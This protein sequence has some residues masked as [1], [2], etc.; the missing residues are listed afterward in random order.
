[1]D[2][3]K[4]AIYAF[5]LPQ[6]HPIKENDIW[7]GKGFTEWT[8]VGKAKK[9]FKQHYQPRV[10]ADLGYYDLRLPDIR[11]MQAELAKTYGI[12][13]FLYWHYWF[14]HGKQLLERPFQ[15][16]LQDKR[17][18][19][20][21]ALAWANE[22]WEI[23]DHKTN[24]TKS[25][26]TQAY[27]SEDDYIKHFM[28]ILQAF[29][30]DRYIKIDGKPLFLIYKPNSIPC[31]E[32]FIEL[33]NKLAIL[34][35]FPGIYFVAHHTSKKDSNNESYEAFAKRMISQGF[36]AINFM[37]LKGF[38]ENRSKIIQTYFNTI[39]HLR[40][41]PLVYPYPKASKYF[42]NKIDSEYNVIPTI[43]SGWDNTPR[44]PNGI[45]L[46]DYTPEAFNNHIKEVCALIK[47]KPP[48]NQ[49]VFL[50]SWNEWAEG[51]YIEPDLKWGHAFLEVI[52]D[53][54]F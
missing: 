14:G 37:R 42:T 39:R 50:K 36:N 38:I 7:W 3:K 34:N 6:F 8:N 5:Y 2:T 21:F 12:D 17:F 13:G 51:N 22:T 43:I 49:I 46:K 33:W 35:G 4:I 54:I 18:T 20:N 45:I 19:L 1:M 29:K 26:I 53:N 30:D 32:S 23:R 40:Y 44:Y 25:L 9:Y 41:K 31:V 27:P 24:T 15:D 10:P 11:I 28:S 52:R 47:N 48:K 16:I